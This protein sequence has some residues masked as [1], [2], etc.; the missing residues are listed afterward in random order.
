MFPCYR[1]K[2]LADILTVDG[3]DVVFVAP[4]NL[5][6]SMGRLGGTN[7]PEVQKVVYRAYEQIIE[8]GR[9][10]GGMAP[11]GSVEAVI[12]KGVQFLLTGW[13]AWMSAGAKAYLDK[14]E[15]ASR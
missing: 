15:S 13:E 6:Q 10:A 1:W 7:D 2:N 8:A 9:V 5:A 4:G 3:I 11:D 12:E 14:I